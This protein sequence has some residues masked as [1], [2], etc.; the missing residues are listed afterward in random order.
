MSRKLVGPVALLL[1]G[2]GTIGC[3]STSSSTSGTGGSAA[4]PKTG[5]ASRTYHLKL[6]GKAETPPG[7]PNG[8]GAAVIALHGSTLRVCWRFSHLHGFQG[9]TFSHIHSGDSG[10]SGRVVIPLSTVPKLHHKGC[11]RASPTVMKAI[12]RHPSGYYVN[13]HSR[14]YPAGAVRAQL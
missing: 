5:V 12:E 10:T 1:I 13:I 3:G 9:A 8:T 14:R 6:T 2:S 4:K 11:V 7:A